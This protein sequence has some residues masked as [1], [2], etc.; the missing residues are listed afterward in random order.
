MEFK[1]DTR[2][3]YTAIELPE[4]SIDATMAAALDEK[5][6]EL[7][8]EGSQNFLIGT[9]ACQDADRE[10]VAALAAMH[11]TCY[12]AGRSIVFTGTQSGV[13]A[14]LK[15]AG[16][17]MALNLAPTEADAV[18]IISMEILERE[19]LSEE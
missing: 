3:A 2:P 19:L 16:L 17:D 14:A 4:G 18:D 15:E 9:A 7:A 5:C 1:I 6:T 13:L 8:E 10:G 12:A 11:E